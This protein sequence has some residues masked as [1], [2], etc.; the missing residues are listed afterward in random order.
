MSPLTDLEFQATLDIMQAIAMQD[1]VQKLA[2]EI[3]L[4]KARN[5]EVSA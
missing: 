5:K 3:A 2:Q 4:I 1:Q